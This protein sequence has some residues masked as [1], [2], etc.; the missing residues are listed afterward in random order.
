M[1][2]EDPLLQAGQSQLTQLFSMSDG[3]SL[4]HLLGLLLDL[5]QCIHIMQLLGTPELDP[6][7]QVWFFQ[8]KQRVKL[9]FHSDFCQRCSL[10]SPGWCWPSRACSTCWPSGSPGP[11]LQSCLLTD[12]SPASAVALGSS[13]VQELHH[14]VS[15]NFSA[16]FRLGILCSAFQRKF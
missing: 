2:P 4:N 11:W 10:H 7:P 15:C 13:Q 12:W 9:T 3:L 16:V 1:S 6:A 14:S 8:N 5:L